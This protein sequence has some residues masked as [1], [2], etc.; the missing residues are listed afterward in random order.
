MCN[1]ASP[2]TAHWE[3]PYFALDTAMAVIQA[4][5]DRLAIFNK[6]CVNDPGTTT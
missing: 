4:Q 3:E 6:I 5:I 1:T 2:E